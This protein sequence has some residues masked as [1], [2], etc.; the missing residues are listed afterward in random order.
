M[1]KLK[2]NDVI[3]Y[4]DKISN[5]KKFDKI[6]NGKKTLKIYFDSCVFSV[7]YFNSALVL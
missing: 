3:F 1:F 2:R 7:A 5:G 4:I 6:S